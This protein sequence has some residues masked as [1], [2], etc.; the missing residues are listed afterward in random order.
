MKV[1]PGVN[2]DGDEKL[3]ESDRG[4]QD[5]DLDVSPPPIPGAGPE[6][7]GS[8][9]GDEKKGDKDDP[10]ATSSEDE[11]VIGGSGKLLEK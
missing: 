4:G 2:G 7:T 11:R 6:E 9:S 1:E 10:L 8:G 5:S 3:Y